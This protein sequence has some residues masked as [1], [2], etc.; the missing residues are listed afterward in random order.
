MSDFRFYI[1]SDL[2]YGHRRK[3]DE[4]TRQ[5]ARYVCENPVD[6][7][8]L[9]GD[10][11]ANPQAIRDCLLLFK[12]FPGKKLVVPGN[13]DV[14]LDKGWNTQ[15]S[16][17]LH[18]SILTDVFDECDFHPLH[19][20]PLTVNGL[21]FVG[22]MGWYD[23]SFRDDIGIPFECYETKTPPWSPMPIWSDARFARF[24]M[25]DVDL[26][27]LLNERMQ[28]QLSDVSSA[29]QVVAMV[30]HV[31]DKSL[32]IHPRTRVPTQW[33]YA[34]AFLG[35]NCHGEALT[36]DPRVQQIFSGHIHME[37]YSPLG[38]VASYTLGSDYRKKQLLLATPTTILEK[39]MFEPQAAWT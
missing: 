37:R 19:M 1:T 33:R 23:Y 10:I 17:E 16:L 7:F 8:L 4:V 11:G 2:H 31:V 39:R 9:G 35:S 30:H 18:D 29:E 24:P 25:N 38:S 34:N 13:H 14:W 28:R 27:H 20:A 15:D 26:T 12:D 5:L 21:A 22:S 36:Q 3:A 6:A 32:L